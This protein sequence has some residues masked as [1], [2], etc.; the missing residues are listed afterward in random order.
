LGK[1]A[2]LGLLHKIKALFGAGNSTPPDARRLSAS[3]ENQLSDSLQALPT[4]EKGWISLRDAWHLFSQVNENDAFGEMDAA[5][6]RRLDE[7]AAYST[8]RSEV[9]FMPVEGRVYFTRK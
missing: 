1:E 2:V 5:G 8:H 7:F 9:D 3:S 6:K 4:G